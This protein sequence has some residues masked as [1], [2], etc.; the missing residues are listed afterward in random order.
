MRDFTMGPVDKPLTSEEIVQKAKIILGDIRDERDRDL[1]TN[2]PRGLRPV[3]RPSGWQCPN[4]GSA[5]APDIATCP[6]PP[7]GGSLRE[8]MKAV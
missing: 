3:S 1:E 6:E 8:R 7:R 5:H 2:P 4:C